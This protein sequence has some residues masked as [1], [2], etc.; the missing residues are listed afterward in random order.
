MAFSMWQTAQPGTFI[1]LAPN[2]VHTFI[3]NTEQDVVD[4]GLAS[5]GISEVFPRLWNSCNRGHEHR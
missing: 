1:E 4:H 5:R 3:N 2:I